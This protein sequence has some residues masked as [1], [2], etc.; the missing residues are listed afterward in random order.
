VYS[1]ASAPL[2]RTDRR[3]PSPPQ[4]SFLFSPR[5]RP[6]SYSRRAFNLQ[7]VLHANTSCHLG[8]ACS[9]SSSPLERTI[10][11]VAKQALATLGRI[12]PQDKTCA[13]T[14]D[15]APGTMAPL[16][17]GD[18]SAALFSVHIQPLYHDSLARSNHLS[19]AASANAVHRNPQPSFSFLFFIFPV[20][21]ACMQ[22]RYRQIFSRNIARERTTVAAPRRARQNEIDK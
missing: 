2:E 1:L 18:R 9:T 20:M 3:F 5:R 14:C 7:T 21:H 11:A 12:L 8:H 6:H 19:V 4:S 10:G 13:T 22:G 16:H 17:A 15:P